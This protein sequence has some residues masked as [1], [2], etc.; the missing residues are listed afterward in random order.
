MATTAP[1][2]REE[3]LPA[4]RE[5]MPTTAAAGAEY[6]AICKKLS[7]AKAKQASVYAVLHPT[8]ATDVTPMQILEARRDRKDADDDVTILSLAEATARRAYE[9]AQAADIERLRAHLLT[10]KRARMPTVVAAL[11]A[12][13]KEMLA[14]QQLEIREAELLGNVDR[15][16]WTTLGQNDQGEHALDTWVGYVRRAGLI[17]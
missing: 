12:A 16:A 7:A 11:R 5:E 9:H 13:E 8:E 15:V 1:A 3:P 14:L 10:L 17:D 2:P 4:T 6:R